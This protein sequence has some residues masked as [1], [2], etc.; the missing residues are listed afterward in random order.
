MQRLLALSVLI[1]H[2]F[3]PLSCGEALVCHIGK[4]KLAVKDLFVS[5][6]RICCNFIW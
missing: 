3:S 5:L 6:L 1:G 2:E 4:V